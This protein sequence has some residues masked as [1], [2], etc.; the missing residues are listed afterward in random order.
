MLNI[1]LQI[2][3]IMKPDLY[4]GNDLSCMDGGSTLWSF[5]AWCVIVT[6]LV[7]VIEYTVV[8]WR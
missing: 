3:K 8:K 4:C 1:D 6:V 7:G 5:V 2:I